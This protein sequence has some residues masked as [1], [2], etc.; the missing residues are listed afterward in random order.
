MRNALH[1]AGSRE[2]AIQLPH[3]CQAKD[4]HLTGVVPH[5]LMRE[6]SLKIAINGSGIV[7]VDTRFLALSSPKVVVR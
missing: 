4:K 1:T 7:G 6:L 2:S 3:S 5:R